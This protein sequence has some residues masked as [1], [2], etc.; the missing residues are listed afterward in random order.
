MYIKT[1][2]RYHFIITRLAKV[3]SFTVPIKIT[4]ALTRWSTFRKLSFRHIY[5][6]EMIHVQ[7]YYCDIICSSKVMETSINFGLVK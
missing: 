5:K 2:V 7:E 3:S 4:N 6:G 1:T